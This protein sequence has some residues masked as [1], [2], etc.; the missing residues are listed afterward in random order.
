MEL[1]FVFLFD[2]M[3]NY[4]VVPCIVCALHKDGADI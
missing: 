3:Q 4:Y 1:Y 2:V